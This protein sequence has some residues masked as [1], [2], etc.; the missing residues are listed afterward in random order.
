VLVLTNAT[1]VRSFDGVVKYIWKIILSFSAVLVPLHAI[2]ASGKIFQ[3]RK[4]QEKA[5]DALKWKIS[6]ASILVFLNF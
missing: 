2:M 5:F 6:K 1:K 4:N 3:W